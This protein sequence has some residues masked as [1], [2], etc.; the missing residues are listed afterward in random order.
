MASG[1]QNR[2]LM[3]PL[4]DMKGPSP[5][6]EIRHDRRALTLEELLHLLDVT[7]KSDWSFRD[8]N[9][10][11][12]FFLYLTAC[13]TG[14]RRKELASLTPASFDLDGDPPTATLPGRLT[15]NKRLATQPLPADVAEALR[16]YL[17]G[18][19]QGTPLWPRKALREIVQALRKTWKRQ[20]FPTSSRAPRDRNT[21]ICTPCGIPTSCFWIRLA[22]PSR[23]R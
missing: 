15:K 5:T 4:A 2:M 12:R 19:P 17:A 21:P 6:E 1:R 22:S 11:D 13:E 23:W 3:N 16:G 8:L 20:A 9:G 10:E 18:R 7:R 14:Y